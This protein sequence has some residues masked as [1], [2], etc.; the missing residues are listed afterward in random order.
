MAT[1]RADSHMVLHTSRV[2]K[3][4]H[5]K[6]L[7]WTVDTD[8]V[9]LAVSMAHVLQSRDELWLAFGTGKSFRYF[10]AKK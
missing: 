6:I 9:L 2:A 5:Y 7:I 8:V 3:H 1:I 4:N 10:A